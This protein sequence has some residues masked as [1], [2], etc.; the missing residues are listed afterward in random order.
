[1][2]HL[3]AA[4]ALAILLLPVIVA[5][6]P[7]KTGGHEVTLFRPTTYE[8]AV[9]ALGTCEATNQA[10]VAQL[11]DRRRLNTCEP[12]FVVEVSGCDLDGGT[13]PTGGGVE[14]DVNI[15]RHDDGA[16]NIEVGGRACP[17]VEEEDSAD[18]GRRLDTDHD[19]A[20]D[21]LLSQRQPAAG[22][23]GTGD[24]SLLTFHYSKSPPSK[25][26]DGDY[27]RDHP[28]LFHS[29]VVVSQENAWLRITLKHRAKNPRVKIY[30]RSCC[31]QSNYGG[32]LFFYL[33]DEKV[34]GTGSL[35]KCG[36][37]TDVTDSST[38]EAT[39]VGE[40]WYFYLGPGAPS[41]TFDGKFTMDIPEVEVFSGI[42]TQDMG[43]VTADSFRLS[44]TLRL[45]QTTG[46]CDEDNAGA[47]VWNA[48]KL[49]VYVCPSTFRRALLHIRVGAQTLTDPQLL[50]SDLSAFVLERVGSLS[51]RALRFSDQATGSNGGPSTV[52]PSVRNPILQVPAKP[53][54][55][56][57]PVIKEMARIGLIRVDML[58]KSFAT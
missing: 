12:P 54:T 52:L 24:Q 43:T 19:E 27:G 10:L 33:S 20:P 13:C 1:M 49:S 50:R 47:L 39:C 7:E 2:E 22:S 30:A 41:T 11:G 56:C 44:G 31:T 51:L 37:I 40:G 57:P 46:T 18:F 53:S 35:E 45:G 21:L 23:W 55:T 42:E 58:S 38:K 17:I 32:T 15:R 48:P 3:R 34:S 28:N 29:D 36:E 26:V 14:I 4:A 8:A 6:E 9:A 25:A 16:M 5:A